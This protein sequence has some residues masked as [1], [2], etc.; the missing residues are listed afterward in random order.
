MIVCIKLIIIDA[1]TTVWKEEG[2]RGLYRGLLPSFFGVSH[3]AVQ[4]VVYEELNKVV[5]TFSKKD[6]VEFYQSLGTGALSKICA[7]LSTYPYQVVKA[8]LQ[9]RPLKKGDPPPY[10]GVLNTIKIT[11]R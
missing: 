10:V 8:R 2:I 7:T 5:R 4:F 1:F 6:S 11:Y 3:G 9:M